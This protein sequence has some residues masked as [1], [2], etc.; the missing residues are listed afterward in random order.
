MALRVFYYQWSHMRRNIDISAPTAKAGGGGAP[1]IE[2]TPEMIDAGFSVLSFEY[3]PDES[4]PS[5]RAV[6]AE[7]YKA[8][9]AVKLADASD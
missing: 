6:I 3:D 9:R 1:D 2:I 4:E 8:M 7:M 5:R